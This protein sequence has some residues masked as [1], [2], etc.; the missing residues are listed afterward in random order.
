MKEELKNLTGQIVQSGIE[1]IKTGSDKL[2]D[3]A[4]NVGD[5][6]KEEALIYGDKLV[7]GAMNV[8]DKLK[9][10]A[11]IYSDKLV[12][13]AVTVGD[14]L[15]EEA[16]AYLDERERKKVWSGYE[17]IPTGSA[18]DRILPGCIVLEG[19]S[20]RGCYTSGFLDVLME[21]GINMQATIG[22][23]AGALNGYNYVAGEIG[24][25]GRINLGYRHDRRYFGPRSAMKSR[26][27]VGFNFILD[28][29]EEELPFDRERFDDPA[30]RFV[31]TVTDCEKG[32]V[33][34]C[35]KGVTPDFR[36]AV[37]ASASMPFV[38]DMVEVDGVP[39]LDGGC[40][41]KIPYRWALDEGYEKV[42]VVRT[43]PRRF[44]R[45]P[46]GKRFTELAERIYRNHP[47]LIELLLSQGEQYN[48]ACDE[49]EKLESEGKL[50]MLCPSGFVNVGTLEGDTEKLGALYLLGRCD[51]TI[52]MPK[53][54]EYLG[55]E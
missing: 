32:E 42:L 49:L 13:G 36:K 29:I 6:L 34:Y 33:R 2:V 7:D 20:F 44:R 11:L 27:V 3:G 45:E 26:G 8:G 41:V 1:L 12:D 40:A 25:S 37:R 35:E 5:K 30:R 21:N 19:G 17:D 15:K 9:E 48:T 22:T 16:V 46:E 4:I 53:I 24:R 54:K 39:C 43:R 14:K 55:I 28:E 52:Y 47:Q 38:S 51:A 18:P 50:L 23:S 10:E 31:V